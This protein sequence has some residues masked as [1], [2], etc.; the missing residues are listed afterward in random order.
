MMMHKGLENYLRSHQMLWLSARLENGVWVDAD[1]KPLE[2]IK[3]LDA[4]SEAFLTEL[5]RYD[6]TCVR[7][8]PWYMGDRFVPWWNLGRSCNAIESATYTPCAYDRFSE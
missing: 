2:F 6:R 1:G 8:V 4:A 5:D 3:N 7:Y